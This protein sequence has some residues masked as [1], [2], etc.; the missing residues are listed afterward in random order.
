M[1]LKGFKFETG[2]QPMRLLYTPTGDL[3]FLREKYIK[4]KYAKMPNVVARGTKVELWDLFKLHAHL[5]MECS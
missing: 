4:P 5:M 3:Y 2:D 1:I